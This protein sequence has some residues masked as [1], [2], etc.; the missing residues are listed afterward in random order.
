MQIMKMKTTRFIISKS[1][2]VGIGLFKSSKA[3]FKI[4]NLDEQTRA[5]NSY[6]NK[7]SRVEASIHGNTSW[8]QFKISSLNVNPE[9]NNAL[10][11]NI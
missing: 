8:N 7:R 11:K 5:I 1:D 10:S 4:K 6:F 3:F 9:E 2:K